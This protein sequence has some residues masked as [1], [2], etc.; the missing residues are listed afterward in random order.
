MSEMAVIFECPPVA[1]EM[2]LGSVTKVKKP[3][4]WKGGTARTYLSDS[5]S[6]L[7]WGIDSSQVFRTW[8]V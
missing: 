4:V 5:Y 6:F 2:D 7:K 1:D 3:G 8:F